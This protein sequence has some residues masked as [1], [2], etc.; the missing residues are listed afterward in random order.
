MVPAPAAAK[1]A[2]AVGAAKPVPSATKPASTIPCPLPD[3][4]IER[5]AKNLLAGPMNAKVKEA[6]RR[7][8]EQ[9]MITWG[10]MTAHQDKDTQLELECMSCAV[11]LRP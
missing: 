7:G 4:R 9:F 8:D 11:R 2:V 10:S 6:Q 5:A 1:A 3:E